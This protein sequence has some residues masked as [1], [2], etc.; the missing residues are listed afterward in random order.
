M[1]HPNYEQDP[2]ATSDL[3]VVRL[4]SSLRFSDYVRPICLS[5]EGR[6]EGLEVAGWGK[7]EERERS[8]TL[9]HTTLVE[10]GVM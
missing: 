8:P 10:V 9:Q 2:L 6:R 4:R 5:L 1:I 7:T 3:A